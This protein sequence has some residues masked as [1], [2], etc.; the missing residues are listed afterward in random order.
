[1]SYDIKIQNYCDHKILWAQA[2]LETDRKTVYFPYPMASAASL[3][4]RVNG[5]EMP[6]SSFNIRTKRQPLSLVVVSNIEFYSKIKHL[7][8]IVELFYVTFPE[9]CPKCLNVKTTDDFFINGSGD[10]EMIS[11]ELLL[12]QRVEKIIVTKVS[13][14]LFHF[15]YG[16]DL[17]SLI[18]TKIFDRTLMETRVREQIA[19]AIEKLKTTQDRMVSSN[20]QFDPGE[21]FGKLLKIE[22]EDTQNPTIML[23]TVSF[24]SQSGTPMEYSQYLS[25]NLT[26]TRQRTVL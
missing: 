8:P 4:V 2:Q 19:N 21:L 15:W 12:L 11:K 25:T 20:R 9:T 3:I 5:V 14:N 1:M 18:G 16:T 26:T 10:Y 17:H 6:S 13:S 24:T 23:V 7:N 22:I